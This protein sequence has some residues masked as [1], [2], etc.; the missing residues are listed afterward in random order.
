MLHNIRVLE[1]F[2]IVNLDSGRLS[3]PVP[4][5][6]FVYLD[7]Y[8]HEPVGYKVYVKDTH[9][10]RLLRFMYD[11]HSGDQRW[12]FGN[13][14]R[15]T[16]FFESEHEKECFKDYIEYNRYDLI[17]RVNSSDEFDYIVTENEVKTAGYKR[18]LRTAVVLKQ[19]LEEFREMDG[20]T[21]V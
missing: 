13:L 2:Q 20:S 9:T 14:E 8:H 1:R 19:M 12:A 5:W 17:E 11:P 4:E 10:E 6:E 15:V 7:K 18:S 16:L 21:E 3:V